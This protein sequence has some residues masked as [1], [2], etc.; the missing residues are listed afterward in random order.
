MMC[1]VIFGIF[2]LLSIVGI[3]LSNIFWADDW[4]DWMKLISG[5]GLVL[6]I[7]FSGVTLACRLKAK[8]QIQCFEETRNMI[9][10]VI[11]KSSET[12]NYGITQTIV[13]RNMWLVEAKASIKKYGV[14]SIYYGL[15]IENLE[16][17]SLGS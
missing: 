15:N 8:E 3:I 5:I 2:A 9:E 14:W 7:F 6:S 11:D 4:S 1:L 13:E 12:E 10:I 16:Y 17:L